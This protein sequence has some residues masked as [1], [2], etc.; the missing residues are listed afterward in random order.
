MAYLTKLL[1][2]FP[3]FNKH[4]VICLRMAIQKNMDARNFGVAARLLGELLTRKGLPDQ[5]SLEQRKKKC[6]EVCAI[7]EKRSIFL[8]LP[9]LTGSCRRSFLMPRLRQRLCVQSVAHLCL[10]V[11][12][13]ATTV[14]GRSLFVIRYECGALS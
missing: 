13:V 11:P 3:I 5:A 10:L 8:L 2:D 1:T 6:E 4:Q 12:L 7:L 9:M 14:R